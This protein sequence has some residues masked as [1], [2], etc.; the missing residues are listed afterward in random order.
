MD[1]PVVLQSIYQLLNSLS[2]RKILTWEFFLS[3]FDVL[4]IEAQL[5]LEKNGDLSYVRDLRNSENGSEIL[6]N[7]ITKARE[8]LSQSSDSTE[9]RKMTKTLSASFGKCQYKRT[10][11]APANFTPRQESKL[12]EP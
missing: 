2:D 3:R 4:F 9:S 5:N 11:S 1:R 6:T 8:A 12:G 10:M 7:K